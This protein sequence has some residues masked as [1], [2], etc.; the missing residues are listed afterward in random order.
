MTGLRSAEREARER[1]L[2]AAIIV[3]PRMEVGEKKMHHTDESTKGAATNREPFAFFPSLSLNSAEERASQTNEQRIGFTFRLTLSGIHA[4]GQSD[5][6]IYV[7]GA[8]AW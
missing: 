1:K 2:P 8:G 4:D 5:R 7:G 3:Y 6:S